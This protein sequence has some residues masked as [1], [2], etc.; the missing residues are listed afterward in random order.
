MSRGFASAPLGPQAAASAR[1][2]HADC[3]VHGAQNPMTHPIAAPLHTNCMCVLLFLKAIEFFLESIGCRV[4]SLM[5][6]HLQKAIMAAGRAVAELGGSPLTM[7]EQQK[8]LSLTCVPGVDPADRIAA[9]SKRLVPHVLGTVPCHVGTKH[10]V[11]AVASS[12]LFGS[13]RS[14]LSYNSRLGPR[15]DRMSPLFCTRRVF[16]QTTLPYM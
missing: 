13:L 9:E 3:A 16:P 2:C 5:G 11:T 14:G 4:G 12:G 6:R 10:R 1:A 8:I 15:S 7:K